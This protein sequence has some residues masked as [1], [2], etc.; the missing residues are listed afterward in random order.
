MI[1]LLH[2]ADLHLDSPFSGL[3]PDQAAARRKLQRQLPEA[4]VDL[5]HQYDC[6]A[7]LLAG[8]VF[9]GERVCPETV[10]ALQRAFARCRVPVCIAPGNHDPY[11]ERSPWAKARWPEQ[12]HIFTGDWERVEL[13]QMT[14]WGGAFRGREAHGLLHPVKPNGK[15]QIALLH[16]EADTADSA[17]NPM[18][19][20][21]IA[22][23]GL[24]Y[25][26]LGHIHKA[27]PPAK[28]GETWYAWP[29]VAM[30]RGFDETGVHGAYLVELDGEFCRATLLPLPGPRYESFEVPA[31]ADPCGAVLAAVPP[32]CR[33]SICRITLTGEADAVDLEALAARLGMPN[34]DLRDETIPRR[35][36]WDACQGESLRALTMQTLKKQYDAAGDSETRRTLALAARYA[37]AA[38]EGREEP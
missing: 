16:G 25:L 24:R 38:L 20:A 3:K 4:L 29:G 15:P 22:A 5:C 32:S 13:P 33:D 36:L 10:E 27:A 14:V 26:A 34:L 35:D 8:D 17:Y 28:A 11:T 30:G 37:L 9:D 31:G 6:D 21:E 12:V 23:S 1:K 19:R 7:L 18:T 2:G